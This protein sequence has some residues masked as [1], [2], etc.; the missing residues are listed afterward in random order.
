MID[1]E[2]EINRIL[3]IK[4]HKTGF[5]L[6]YYTDNGFSIARS[7]P[8]RHNTVDGI[9]AAYEEACNKFGNLPIDCCSSG[10]KSAIT[11]LKNNRKNNSK[12]YIA[13][14]SE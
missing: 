13:V 12:S 3:N 14:Y 7:F 2:K 1:K 6:K 10:E 8:I 9:K 11:V 4:S 5:P